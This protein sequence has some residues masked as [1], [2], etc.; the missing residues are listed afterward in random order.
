M[1][2]LLKKAFDT[3]S[4]RASG[5]QLVDLLADYL[6]NNLQQQHDKVYQWV[7]P[8]EQLAYWQEFLQQPGT[9]TDELYRTVLSR[10]MHTHHTHYMGHQVAVTAPVGA[11]SALFGALLNNGTAV[12]EMGSVS[13]VMEKIII[14]E[15]A[16]A[17]G[18]EPAAEGYLTSGGTLANL[19]ALLAARRNKSTEDVWEH[20]NDIPFAVMVSEEAHYCVDRA[21]RIMGWGSGGIIK[22]PVNADYT[23]NTNLLQAAYDTATANGRKVIAIVGSACST[24]TGAYD[25]LEA[26]GAFARKHD[27]WFHVDGAH[28][29]AAIFSSKY[30]YLLKGVEVADSVV[31]DYH[32]MLLTPALTTALIFR[33]GDHSYETFTQKAQY[34]WE[35]S[36]E[37]DWYNLARRT[38]ECTKHMMALR[39]FSILSSYGVQVFD[40]TVTTLYDLGVSFAGMINERE[41][42]ELAVA[43]LT[44]IVCFRYNSGRENANTLNTLNSNIRKRL[45]ERGNFYIVQTLLRGETWLRVSLMNPF[46]GKEELIRLLDEVEFLANPV[47]D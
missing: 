12:Y 6:D 23:M 1:T 47:M 32:K 39:V 44:N 40:D 9:T 21:V 15:T 19:T 22:V 27:L 20:G 45:V 35:K 29:G 36:D 17:I 26:V 38:F 18:F 3:N 31:I 33:N 16:K 8:G 42:F 46:T 14:A 13:S 24:S 7:E 4:F 5:H 34:L 25:N 10:S 41:H 2:E 11:L 37:R 43:P 30:A 28:G